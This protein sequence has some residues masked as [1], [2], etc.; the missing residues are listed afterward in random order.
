MPSL[1]TETTSIIIGIINTITSSIIGMAYIIYSIDKYNNRND[2]Y[3]SRNDQ[4]NKMND[5]Y[6]KMNDLYNNRNDQ[7]NIW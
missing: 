2:Q 4:Y 1:I 7:Y 6:D 5:D 3:N